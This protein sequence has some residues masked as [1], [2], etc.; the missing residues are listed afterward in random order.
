VDSLG[1][2]LFRRGRVQEARQ[3][4]EK[5]AAL[6]GGSDDPVVWDHLGDVYFRLSETGKARDAWRK[7]VELYEVGRRRPQDDRLK[8]IKQKLQTLTAPAPG[9]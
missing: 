6:P 5:A 4:L 1:W 3:E 9:R 2:V 8:D 7:A